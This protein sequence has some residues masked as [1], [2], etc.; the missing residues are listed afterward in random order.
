[1]RPFITQLKREFWECRASFIKAPIIAAGIL[2]GLLLIGVAPW[3]H[4]I[5]GF[6][7]HHQMAHPAASNMGAHIVEEMGRQQTV[8]TDPGYL[9]HG[10]AAVYSV[11]ALILL[12][13]LTFYFVDTLYSDR[14][15]QSILFWKSMPV[16]EST[17]VLVKLV[18]GIA[19]APAFYAVAAL[20]TGAFLLLA[21]L[22]YAG[23]LW[24]IP[25]PGAGAVLLTFIESSLGLI[26]GWWFLALW[27]LPIFCWLLFSSAFVR[28]APFL[29][30]LGAP[31]AALVIEK[32]VF[33]SHLIFSA[34]KDQIVAGFYSFQVLVHGPGA[35]A[36]QLVGTLSAMSFWTGLAMSAAWIVASVWLRKNR[37]EI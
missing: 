23:L 17:N 29:L 26:L 33:G 36:D 11:F 37:W 32:W 28:K 10:L 1:M 13:V 8:T 22:V 20:V 31:L 35:V 25:V 3:H 30:A 27:Y 34:I 19:G 6:I 15:D 14:R 21:F 24:N 16:A 7:E 2:T 4:K 18:T 9:V 5:A 12:L